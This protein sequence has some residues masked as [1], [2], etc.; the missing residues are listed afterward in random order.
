MINWSSIDCLT[1]REVLKSAAVTVGTPWIVPS[2]VF[3]ANAP[4]NRIN[5]ACIGVGH[6]GT[7]VPS[8]FLANASVQVVAVCDVNTVGGLYKKEGDI[9][10][11]EPAR[12]IANAWYEKKMKTAS[13]DGCGAYNDFRDVLARD[14]IDAVTVVTP[15]HWHGIITIRAAEAGKDIYCEKPLSLTIGEGRAMV[16]AAKKIR[17]D[18][19]SESHPQLRWSAWI[20][21]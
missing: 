14:D 10:G 7:G 13:Y 4:S 9:R 15:D 20:S 11:R 8:R 5:V 2:S 16:E 12:R 3:G 6:Q 18:A 1:R 19:A 21:G 17:P